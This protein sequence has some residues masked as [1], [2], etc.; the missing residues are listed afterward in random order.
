M[1]NA[2]E[3]LEFIRAR[4]AAD[5]ARAVA[6]IRQGVK[7]ADVLAAIGGSRARMYRAIAI[8]RQP[9]DPLLS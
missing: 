5:G 4:L 7:L 9:K 6:M 8:A 1:L 3:R 2:R